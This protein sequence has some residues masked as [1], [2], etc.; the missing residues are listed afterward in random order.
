MRVEYNCKLRSEWAGR[1]AESE[2]GRRYVRIDRTPPSAKVTRSYA[3][4][5]RDEMAILTQLRTRHVTLNAYLKRIKAVDS[6]LCQSCSEPETVDH[7]LLRCHRFRD[8]RQV[9]RSKLRGQP[10]SLRTLLGM[11]RNLP[12]L[13]SYVKATD[14]LAP[15]ATLSPPSTPS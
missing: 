6:S 13:M 1:W 11:T 12:A 7:F 5:K 8:A 4:L 9:L 2:R 3:G 14:R 10:L 15:R